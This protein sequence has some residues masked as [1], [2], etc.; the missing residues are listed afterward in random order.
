METT[1]A[2]CRLQSRKRDN[3][4]ATISFMFRSILIL[5]WAVL[6]SSCVSGP[7]IQNVLKDPNAVSFKSTHRQDISLAGP[8][9]LT[10][11]ITKPA[12]NGPFPA[13]ILLH[14]CG[15]LSANRDNRW[16]ERLIGWG[17][18]TL[19][20]DSLGPR[21]I[22]SVCSYRFEES[23]AFVQRR[24]QD[25]FDARAY[26][27]GLPYV[28]KSRIAVMG[29]SH[30]GWT[31]LEVILNEQNTFIAAIAFYPRCSGTLS[32]LKIP[33]LI[34]I[35]EKD[36]WTPANACLA[37][38]PAQTTS[39]EQ[40]LKVYPG[41]YHGFDTPGAD[42]VVTGASGGHRLLY[43]QEAEADAIVRVKKFLSEHL[44]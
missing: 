38:M 15:G 34:L 5:L 12:G 20:V 31:T 18:V 9:M 4:A 40:T 10:A 19:Q 43:N 11:R 44:K 22:R 3:S 17:Y 42:F 35:G 6:A 16:V 26:L 29:W 32:G 13:V 21:G 24:V 8:L 1:Q 27:T 25:A 30:G 37:M 7:A 36:D 33:L 41:A 2:G 39:P 28:D 14:G 23:S